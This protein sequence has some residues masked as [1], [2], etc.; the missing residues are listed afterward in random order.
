ML[1]PG[2]PD[3]SACTRKTERKKGNRKTRKKGKEKRKEINTEH[4]LHILYTTPLK[5]TNLVCNSCSKKSP[6]YN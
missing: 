2:S 1:T 3:L 4:K 5:E 6:V